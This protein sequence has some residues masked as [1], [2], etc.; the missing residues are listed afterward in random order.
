MGTM[1]ELVCIACP[2]GCH[3][4]AQD[5]PGG[6]VITGNKCPKGAAY[7]LE[8]VTS[9]KRTVTAVVRTASRELPFAPVRTSERVPKEKIGEVLRAIYAAHVAAPLARGAV[10]IGNVCGTG[11]DVVATRTVEQ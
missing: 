8:E 1:R 3:L 4:T 7:G 11:A 6:T 9:P 5:G 10:V 2:N